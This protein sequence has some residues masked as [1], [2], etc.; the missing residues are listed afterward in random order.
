MFRLL[1]SSGCSWVSPLQQV[2]LDDLYPWKYGIEEV[3]FALSSGFGLSSIQCTLEVQEENW[4]LPNQVE[5]ISRSR[6]SKDRKSKPSEQVVPPVWQPQCSNYRSHS[7]FK[8]HHDH[9][10]PRF[11]E[12]ASY[13]NISAHVY[14]QSKLQKELKSLHLQ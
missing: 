12:F 5:R 6:P 11:G 14:I 8:L 2:L 9:K 10:I 7:K 4:I 1:G 13:C 3:M